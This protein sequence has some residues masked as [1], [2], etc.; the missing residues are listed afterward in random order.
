MHTTTKPPTRLLV[1]APLLIGATACFVVWPD[2]HSVPT[3]PRNVLPADR[4]LR[5]STDDADAALPELEQRCRERAA[6]LVQQLGPGLRTLVRPPFVLA[7]G[8]GVDLEAKY[9]EVV[10][11]TCDFLARQFFDQPPTQPVAILLFSDQASYRATAERLFYDRDVSRFGYYKPGRRALLANLAGGDAALRHELVH[12]LM[13][14]DWPDAPPWLQEGL[15]TMYE[16]VRVV[17][18]AAGCRWE[19][20]PTWRLGILQQALRDGRVAPVRR[21][22]HAQ[23]LE[24]PEEAVAYAHACYL[25]VYLQQQGQL[26]SVYRSMRDNRTAD[27]S[28]E[29]ALLAHHPSQTWGAFDRQLHDWIRTREPIA[30]ASAR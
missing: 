29:Q 12:A 8:P 3:P 22:L 15:A 2:K 27:R 19:P 18:C 23:R 28:G 4:A 20:L 10:L 25:C 11:P 17:D 26:R 16:S 24:G 9:K 6:R 14:A 21:L 1:I 5:A 7:G 13:Q 30:H